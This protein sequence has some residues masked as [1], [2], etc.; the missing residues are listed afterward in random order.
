MDSSFFG[1]LFLFLI[2]RRESPVMPR[3]W[4]YNSTV[5]SAG[6]VDD[7]SATKAT[8]VDGLGVVREQC[9]TVGYSI[10]NYLFQCADGYDPIKW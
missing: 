1:F 5:R 2:E 4:D 3:C 9:I 7:I 8:C 6:H 10:N